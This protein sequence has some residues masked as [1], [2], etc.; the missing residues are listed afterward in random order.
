MFISTIQSVLSNIGNEHR[1]W[2]YQ[3]NRKLNAEEQDTIRTLGHTF[4]NEWSSHGNRLDAQ[5]TVMEGLFIII[6]VD[7]QKAAASG[8]SIDKSVHWIGN[9]EKTFNITLMD[10]MQ[11]AW[12]AKDGTLQNGNLAAFKQEIANGSITPKTHVMDNTVTLGAA[13]KTQWVRPA[14]NTWLFRYFN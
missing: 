6:S 5:C 14:E 12:F 4:C 11:I 2:V 13:L 8:C 10:R 1:V 7:A 3:S 9:L